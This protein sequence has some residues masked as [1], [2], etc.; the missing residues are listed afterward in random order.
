VRLDPL[1]P[2]V[3]LLPSIDAAERTER[4]AWG[5]RLV[6]V[7]DGITESRDRAGEEFGERRVD[8]AVWMAAARSAAGMC[9]AIVDEVRQFGSG[10]P[11]HDD[12]TVVAALLTER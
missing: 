4:L 8:Q 1:T 9:T 11:Q 7:S 3:G 2:P 6:I 10:C 5:D 12:R